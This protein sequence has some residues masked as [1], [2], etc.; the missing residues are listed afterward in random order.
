MN[1][2]ILFLKYEIMYFSISSCR[3]PKIFLLCTKTDDVS[4]VLPPEVQSSILTLS[5]SLIQKVTTYNSQ[6]RN[7][8][9][10]NEIFHTSSS[11]IP[12]HGDPRTSPEDLRELLSAINNFSAKTEMLIPNNWNTFGEQL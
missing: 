3:S 5:K 9:L 4:E 7:V 6:V 2:S 10:V 1:S 12:R 8:F 11:T